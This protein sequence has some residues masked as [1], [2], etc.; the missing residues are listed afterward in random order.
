MK[1]GKAIKIVNALAKG[2]NPRTG[3]EF[4]EKSPYRDQRTIRA[5]LMAT[6]V[7]EQIK[8]NEDRHLGNAG[9]PWKGKEER[10]LVS[11]FD[12]GRKISQLAKEHQR[13][14]GAIRSRL[15]HLGKVKPNS[16]VR[17]ACVKTFQL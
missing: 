6:K 15:L 17:R 8:K 5:L 14:E 11:A 2:V 9:T 12:A 16:V 4:S 7:L 13:T 10:Q 3:A 1:I